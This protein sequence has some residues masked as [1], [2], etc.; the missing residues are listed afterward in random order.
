MILSTIVLCLASST[1]GVAVEPLEPAPL[2]E[3][4]PQLG[5]VE[6]VPL[7]DVCALA[8]WYGD[9]ICDEVCLQPDPDCG[10]QEDWC[11]QQGW[12]GDG[13]CDEVC[14]QPDPDCGGGEPDPE[15]GDP[16]GDWCAQEGWYGDGVCDQDCPSPDPDC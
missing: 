8:G 2:L 6:L 7:D 3:P 14:L 11:A 13:I 10:V 12:Y 1:S 15:G 5:P 4:G 9:G 16:Q